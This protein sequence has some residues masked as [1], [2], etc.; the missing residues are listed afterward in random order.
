MVNGVRSGAPPFNA[1]SISVRRLIRIYYQCANIVYMGNKYKVRSMPPDQD[2]TTLNLD[3]WELRPSCRADRIW[4]KN[5]GLEGH[6][7]G[8]PMGT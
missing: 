2:E 1:H 8:A 5:R 4:S 6:G 3:F 7:R